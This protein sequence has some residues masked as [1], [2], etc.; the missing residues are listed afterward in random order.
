MPRQRLHTLHWDNIP[1]A[2]LCGLPFGKSFFKHLPGPNG[3][4]AV[5]F[6]EMIRTEKALRNAL[7]PAILKHLQSR[8][9]F[10]LC[11]QETYGWRGLG[12]L[13]ALGLAKEHGVAAFWA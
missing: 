1:L 9:L 10:R 12:T 7:Q 11:T 8:E 13:G 5:E 2:H 3:D 6:G 4:F